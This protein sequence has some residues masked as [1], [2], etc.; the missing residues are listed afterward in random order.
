MKIVFVE[1]EDDG[2]PF[3]AR[4]L[5]GHGVDFAEDIASVSRDAESASVCFNSRVGADFLC[6]HPKQKLVASGSS[7]RDH[8]GLK[9]AARCGVVLAHQ[10][11]FF[12]THVGVNRTEAFGPIN[13]GP[14][15]KT[16]D[17]LA[18]ALRSAAVGAP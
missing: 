9:A 18:G 14:A 8:L 5:A 10:N 2:Q 11:V 17:F 12:T 6:R 15:P 1:L 3:L 4:S 16:H 13:L 7:A